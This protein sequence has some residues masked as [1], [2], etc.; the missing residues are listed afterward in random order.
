MSLLD[1]TPTDAGL[2]AAFQRA[3]GALDPTRHPVISRWSRAL[4]LGV[5]PEGDPESRELVGG[6]ALAASRERAGR[7]I[8]AADDH[9]TPRLDQFS[10]ADFSLLLTDDTGLILEAHAGGAFDATARRLH[11]RSGG[12]WTEAVQGTNA[13]GTALTE[14]RPVTVFGAAHFVRANHA[15]VC[16]ASPIFDPYGEVIGVLDATSDAR[17]AS[18]AIRAAIDQ[19]ARAIQLGLRDRAWRNA[20]EGLVGPIL[21][22]CPAPAVLVEWPGTV[23]RAN[24]AACRIAGRAIDGAAIEALCGVSWATLMARRHAGEVMALRWGTDET[25]RQ[26]TL[27]P[28]EGDQG[29]CLGVLLIAEP[30]QRWQPPP[31]TPPSA[32]EAAFAPILGSDP[33]LAR[34]RQLAAR[35]ARSRLPV[36][37]LAETG[38]GKG[39]LAQAIH[40]ASDRAA[41]PLVDINCGALTPSLLESELFGYAPGAFTGAHRDGRDGKIHA[42]TGGTLFLDEIGE[43]SPRLQAM[44]L[45]VLEGGRYTRIGE[46]T[47]RHADL[48]LICATCRDLEAMIGRG[49]FRS[50][51]YYR[52]RGAVLRL[53]TLRDRQDLLEVATGLLDRLTT[54]RPAPHLSSAAAHALLAHDWPGNVRELRMALEYALTLCDGPVIEPAHLP[55]DLQPRA[56]VLDAAPTTLLGTKRQ[57]LVRVLRETTGNISEAARRMGVARS[58]IYR[59]M[60]RHG[61]DPTR[62]SG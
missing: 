23:R 44:L 16:Y 39:L 8:A 42:A 35:V 4:G 31:P 14:R 36:L 33:V 41:G 27:H 13:I 24:T 48:R 11:L 53:P 38:T 51:L 50:D 47:P 57:A 34:T 15:L 19:G 6:G 56:P 5:R 2:W 20:G 18:A 46:N 32:T 61:I 3:A 45:K 52:I 43:M 54:R 28:V 49:A 9:L 7:L 55:I 59:M 29:R 17:A 25:P 60:R 12:R 22:R 26:L 40:D 58:T 21:T 10:R 37:L 1:L 62:W 30:I